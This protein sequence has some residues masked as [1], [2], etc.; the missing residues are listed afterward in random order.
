MDVVVV[1][2]NYN[3]SANSTTYIAYFLDTTCDDA[4]AVYNVTDTSTCEEIG[5]FFFLK[6]KFFF[7]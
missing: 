7:S 5:G 6:E 4:A 1:Y 2:V 3:V